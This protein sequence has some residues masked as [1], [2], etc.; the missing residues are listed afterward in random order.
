MNDVFVIALFVACVFLTF[1]LVRVCA[2]LA[3]VLPAPGE[4]SGDA[5]ASGRTPGEDMR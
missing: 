1:G 5:S 3:P 2:W 4:H